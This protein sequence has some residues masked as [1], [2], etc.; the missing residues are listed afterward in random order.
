M[1]V[2]TAEVEHQI[3]PAQHWIP[4]DGATPDFATEAAREVGAA[5]TPVVSAGHAMHKRRLIAEALDQ[6]HNAHEI[7]ER[8]D[9]AVEH[10]LQWYDG[11]LGDCD[12]I[13]IVTGVMRVELSNRRGQVVIAEGERRGG[14]MKSDQSKAAPHFDNA[15]KVQR[16]TDR[17][18]AE[19]PVAVKAYVDESIKAVHSPS[20]RGAFKAARKASTKKAY[21]KKAKVRAVPQDLDLRATIK[22]WTT[23]LRGATENL[24]GITPIIMAYLNSAPKSELTKEFRAAATELAMALDKFSVGNTPNLADVGA[25]VSVHPADCEA[26]IAS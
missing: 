17:A 16:Q 3:V 24:T 11:T 18:I 10:W 22:S 15:E 12:R 26:H 8:G 25:G 9:A 4:D 20:V 13:R 7:D 23:K 19:N 21:I 5:L 14:D 1:D 2:T 6:L